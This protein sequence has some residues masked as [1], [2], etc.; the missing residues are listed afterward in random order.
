MPRYFFH[1]RDGIEHL[2]HEGVELAGIPEARDMALSSTAEAIRD[3]GAQFWEDPAWIAWVTDENG[4][5]VCS[6]RVSIGDAR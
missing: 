1:Y 4:A 5:T 3:L 6:L 2:D